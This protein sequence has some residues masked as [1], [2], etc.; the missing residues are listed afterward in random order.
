MQ[1]LFKLA[2][3]IHKQHFMHIKSLVKF[4]DTLKGHTLMCM[5]W[6]RLIEAHP[7]CV[8]VVANAFSY[9]RHF[10]IGSLQCGHNSRGRKSMDLFLSGWCKATSLLTFCGSAVSWDSTWMQQP[11]HAENLH[12]VQPV[13]YAQV[14]TSNW[15][16]NF[17]LPE[18][19][20]FFCMSC[21]AERRS[22]ALICVLPQTTD[23]SIASWINENWSC[24]VGIE[25]SWQAVWSS[26][27]NGVGVTHDEA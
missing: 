25:L 5:L 10:I 17:V 12:N 4:V 2:P 26:N 15:T 1:G 16:S 20:P 6:Y 11:V 27:S 7:S 13:Y 9:I 21:N 24:W 23:S 19:G 14:I 3:I 22:P 18:T 8:Q